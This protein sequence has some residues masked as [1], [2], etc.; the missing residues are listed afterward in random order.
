MA[1]GRIKNPVGHPS[2]DPTGAPSVRVSFC[3]TNEMGDAILRA[4]RKTKLKLSEWMRDAVREK[5]E[6]TA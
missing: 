6:R 2:L 4:N 3:I 1:K 5:L